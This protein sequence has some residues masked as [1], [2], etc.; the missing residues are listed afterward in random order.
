MSEYQ[1]YEFK[2]IDKPLTPKEKEVVSSWSSRTT[3]KNSGAIFIYH[4]SD[5]PKDE[6]EVVKQ[7][8][9]A[10]FYIANWGSK[11]LIFKIPKEFIDKKKVRQYCVE[12]LKIID[13]KDS[14]LIDFWIEDDGEGNDWI[15]GEGILASL[16]T[17]RQD[18]ISGDYRSLYLIW[19]KVSTEDVVNDYGNVNSESEESV[20][21]EG[22][23]ELSGSLLDFV[24][25]FDIDKD[26]I[27]AAAEV[28][29]PLKTMEEIDYSIELAKLTDKEKNDW[30]M[31]LIGN[32]PLLSEKIKR[33]FSGAKAQSK[34]TS[35]RTIANIVKNSLSLKEERKARNK[36]Q[37]EEQFLVKLKKIEGKKDV[38]W[39]QVYSLIKQ[40]QAKAYDEAIQ[41]LLSLKELAV[42]KQ[43]FVS[44]AEKVEFIKQ[45][46][47]NLTGLKRRIDSA[48]LL[49][50]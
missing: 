32:E 26:T 30:L 24:E 46:N 21:P 34:H 39:G 3:A 12:G 50:N 11:R 33:H 7:Y 10:M 18:I 19:L 49:N 16:I 13:Y 22:L 6:L 20:I 38:L 45:Q 42:F 23:N 29:E 44:F 40:K 15:E 27:S 14:V 1:F 37:R 28:S 2:A 4:Y 43:D 5:F 17:L 41:I 47:R 48:K 8:F 35:K 36:K 25:I 31:R 9:D